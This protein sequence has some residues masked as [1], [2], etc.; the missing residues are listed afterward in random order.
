MAL[1]GVPVGALC[2]FY[3][4]FHE[5]RDEGVKRL[6]CSDLHGP[7]RARARQAVRL[8]FILEAIRVR[9][10]HIVEDHV[11]VEVRATAFG[12]EDEGVIYTSE[13]QQWNI[14]IGPVK[15][16]IK[17]KTKTNPRNKI[18]CG[19]LQTTERKYVWQCGCM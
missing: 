17:P 10:V 12:T 2:H 4:P 16:S 3:V 13:L 7:W 5:G 11:V 6:F 18:M 19:V 8:T 9:A 15:Q 1:L 14:R